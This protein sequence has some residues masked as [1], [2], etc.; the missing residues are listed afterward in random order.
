MLERAA[1]AVVLAGPVRKR[2]F[3]LTAQPF[4]YAIVSSNPTKHLAPPRTVSGT[5]HVG[6]WDQIGRLRQSGARWFRHYHG[7]S[8]NIVKHLTGALGTALFITLASAPAFA[9]EPGF[10]NPGE[11]ELECECPQDPAEFNADTCSLTPIGNL[12]Y[13]DDTTTLENYVS[14]SWDSEDN[15]YDVTVDLRNLPGEGVM[16]LGSNAGQFGDLDEVLG[17]LSDVFGIQVDAPF[18]SQGQPYLLPPMRINQTGTSTRIDE[19]TG[20]WA[21]ENSHNFIADILTDKDGKMTIGSDVFVLFEDDEGCEG[22]DSKAQDAATDGALTGNQC[23][24]GRDADY[25]D[26][27]D[28]GDARCANAPPACKFIVRKATTVTE[29]KSTEFILTPA[30][31]CSIESRYR[32]N[33]TCRTASYETWRSRPTSTATQRTSRHKGRSSIRCPSRMCRP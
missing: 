28:S 17:F 23:S 18:D 19:A 22:S 32:T 13:T 4:G 8:M 27:T 16:L 11:D 7:Q 29:A 20:T 15:V 2:H 6:R 21:P 10:C 31:S 12:I 1:D 30:L 25:F 24:W 14:A 33:A 5:V 9:V 26:R 3:E